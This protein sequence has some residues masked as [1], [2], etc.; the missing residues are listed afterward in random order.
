MNQKKVNEINDQRKIEMDEWA[1]SDLYMLDIG[2]YNP[3]KGF[4]SEEDYRSCLDNMRLTNG[5]VWSLP[6]VLPASEEEVAILA[7][8]QKAALTFKEELYGEIKIKEIYKVDRS[9]EAEKVFLTRDS[10]HP[11]VQATLKRKPY[12]ISGE[13]NFT[14]KYQ[15]PF[16]HYPHTPTDTKELFKQKG[17]KTVVAFQTRNPIHRAHE[18]IQKCALEITDGLFIHP[19]VGKTKSDDVP[20]EVRMSCYETL[21]NNYYPRDRVILGVFPASMRYAG[22]REA[23]FHALVRRNYGCTHFIVGRDHAG[24][25]NYYGTY[26]SQ[27]IFQQFSFDELGIIPL[28][29]EHSFYCKKCQQ[30]TSLKTCPHPPS[31]HLIFSGTKVRELLRQGITPPE[32]FSRKEVADLLINEMKKRQDGSET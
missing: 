8:N 32:E 17:W 30:I 15:F 9:E 25:G 31:S 5:Q 19:L 24:V 20:V 4:M 10:N 11:G 18:Y 2:A 1:L 26:D 14:R 22:P 6:I 16:S 23:L 7:I 21:I 12:N 27:K 28:F 13:V 29:F 3:L